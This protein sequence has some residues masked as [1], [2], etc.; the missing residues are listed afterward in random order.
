MDNSSSESGNI[1]P[2]TNSSDAGFPN[3]TQSESSSQAP[4]DLINP[5]RSDVHF[6]FPLS[7]Q[8]LSVVNEETLSNAGVKTRFPNDRDRHKNSDSLQPTNRSR[9]Q[10][11]VSVSIVS[12]DLN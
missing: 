10:S 5:N 9:I 4:A 6:F 8:H 7:N 1:Y 11:S 3:F 12:P 2:E